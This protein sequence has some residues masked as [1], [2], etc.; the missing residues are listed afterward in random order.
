MNAHSIGV[1]IID[2]SNE[3]L[4][5]VIDMSKY[6][7]MLP[8]SCPTLVITAPGFETASVHEVDPNFSEVFSAC[9]LEI[10][11]KNCDCEFHTLPDGI[12]VVKYSVSPHEQLYAE[13]NH[14]RLTQVRNRIAQEYCDLDVNLCF[15]DKDRRE[16]LMQLKEISA[17][18]DAAKYN[19]E[20]CHK[21]DKGMKIYEYALKQLDKI[22][23]KEC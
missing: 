23:C 10:Q 2:T 12:Y 6:N 9:D 14:L 3:D 19:I 20:Y 18:L 17:Y 22:S 11:I 5:K 1:E 21:T 4:F 16:K 13:Y 7:P 8:I 15:T